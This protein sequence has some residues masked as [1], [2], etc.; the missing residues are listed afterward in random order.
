MKS[1]NHL[2]EKFISDENIQLAIKNASKGKKNRREVSAKIADP[3][4]PDHIKYQFFR[5]QYIRS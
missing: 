1:Y 5:L 4:F 2:W 3:D